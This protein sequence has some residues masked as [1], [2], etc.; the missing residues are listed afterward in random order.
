MY[1]I[2]FYEDK[3]GISPILE[4]IQALAH[5]TDKDSRINHNKINDYIQVLSEYG[6]TAGEPYIKHLDGEIWEL[7]PIRGRIFFAGW[8]NNGFIL[9]HHFQFKKTQKTPKHEIDQAKR[10]LADIRERSKR[11]EDMERS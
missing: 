6:K 8:T 1:E 9:L 4:Y 7:R 10:N 5:K 2:Y 3:N 11:N